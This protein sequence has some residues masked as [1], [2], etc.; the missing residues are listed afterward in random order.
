MAVLRYHGAHPQRRLHLEKQRALLDAINSKS[1]FRALLILPAKV[2]YFGHRG[3]FPV[4]PAQAGIQD[5]QNKH[6]W[7]PALKNVSQFLFLS[8]RTSEAIF[9][10]QR[11]RALLDPGS[12][13]AMLGLAGMTDCG[14]AAFAGLKSDLS[15]YSPTPQISPL[16]PPVE[17]DLLI[18]YPLTFLISS[19]RIG[20]TSNRSPTMP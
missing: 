12:R 5:A 19:R 2:K 3:V 16:R 7:I 17:R 10:I 4:M 8:F 9:G 1:E 11:F 6:V 18:C 15:R 20:T 13:R 14:T